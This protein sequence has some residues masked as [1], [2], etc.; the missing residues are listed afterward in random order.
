MT[1]EPTVGSSDGVVGMLHDAVSRDRPE[2]L[3][4]QVDAWNEVATELEYQAGML[5]SR[6][7]QVREGWTS[8]G[9]AVYLTQLENR[10]DQLSNNAYL[11][12]RNARSWTVVAEQ[13]ASAKAQAVDIMARWQVA[14][15]SVTPGDSGAL[16]LARIPFD[17]EAQTVAAQMV[18]TGANHGLAITPVDDYEPMPGNTE[19]PHTPDGG[20][21]NADAGGPPSGGDAAPNAPRLP[22]HYDPA[23]PSPQLQGPGLPPALTAPPA[24]PVAPPGGWIPTPPPPGGPGVGVV[25]PVLPPGGGN[26]PV[27]P[28]RPVPGVGTAP[29]TNPWT[30]RTPQPTVRP[31]IGTRPGSSGVAP[32][33]PRGNSGLNRPVID[34]RSGT[35]RGT[36]SPNP[37]PSNGGSDGMRPNR[38]ASRNPPPRSGTPNASARSS[39][40][41]GDTACP[42]GPGTR[43]API[44]WGGT[45]MNRSV[46]S[47]ARPVAARGS[48]AGKP[49]RRDT[50]RESVITSGGD[51]QWH[52]EG[53]TVPAVITGGPGWEGVEH[54]SPTTLEPLPQAQVPIDETRV[55]DRLAQRAEDE[56]DADSE[57]V[58]TPPKT[59]PAVIRPANEV[60]D[61]GIRLV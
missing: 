33:G 53:A 39:A 26:S 43:S 60:H 21:P 48:S 58:W 61:F 37:N 6:T 41:V 42:K 14:K 27:R 52:P 54:Q 28:P 46:I 36:S 5:Q 18:E 40:G 50:D 59:V 24:P 17:A 3:F 30:P 12:S 23:A 13:V 25:P 9:S 56:S 16:A 7:D 38:H 15:E 29:R 4:E 2:D 20:Q 34:G 57:Q 31:V 11:A 47:D 51:Y 45:G 22:G 35:A 1:F 8:E 19:A 49:K 32:T 44:Y 55:V 10:A